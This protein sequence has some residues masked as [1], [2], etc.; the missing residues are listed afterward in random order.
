MPVVGEL[1]EVCT[2]YAVFALGRTTKLTG[3]HS[4]TSRGDSMIELIPL[5]WERL[6][7]VHHIASGLAEMSVF[8]VLE[9][10]EQ[11]VEG[12]RNFTKLRG[13]RKFRVESKVILSNTRKKKNISSKLINLH[14]N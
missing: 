14:P 11:E 3:K 10:A 8:G 7:T 13:L 9:T 6:P 1:E 5:D 4:A 2:S 12:E